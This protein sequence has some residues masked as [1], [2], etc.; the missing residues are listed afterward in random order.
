MSGD[1]ALSLQ[2]CKEDYDALIGPDES[3]RKRFY[4]QFVLAAVNCVH[5]VCE[6][7]D[8]YH[9]GDSLLFVIDEGNKNEDELK[10]VSTRSIVG[11]DRLIKDVCTA[12]DKILPPLQ[13]A[14]LLAFELC[15]ERRT[16]AT[17]PTRSS[18]K[19]SRYP[20]LVLNE[21]PHDWVMVGDAHL[22][23]LALR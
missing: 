5:A 2:G 21:H 15:S 1:L 10:Q 8:Q 12:D 3:L 14:D 23:A 6:W 7:R 16:V 4:S 13:A 11:D 17:K 18:A 19:Y 20:L 9:I 22:R